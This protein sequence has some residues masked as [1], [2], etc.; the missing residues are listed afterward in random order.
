M[1]KPTVGRI[2]HFKDAREVINAAIITKVWGDTVVDLFLLESRPTE[3]PDVV[4]NI[5]TKSSA[6]FGDGSNQWSWPVIER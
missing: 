5:D 4:V 6:N 2:V 3:K 1:Q